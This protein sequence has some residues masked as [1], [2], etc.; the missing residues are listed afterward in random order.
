MQ[1]IKVSINVDY[2]LIILLECCQASLMKINY[3]NA[4]NQSINKVN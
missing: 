1:L 2:K 3:N 4:F